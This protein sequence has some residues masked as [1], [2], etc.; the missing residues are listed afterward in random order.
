M[1]K[2]TLKEMVFSRRD[3]L[4]SKCVCE[5][6]CVEPPSD[7]KVWEWY[8]LAAVSA[9]ER[10]LS[11]VAHSLILPLQSQPRFTSRTLNSFIL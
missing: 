4:H 2:S 5:C 6:A 10:V 3:K 11:E 7:S 9:A 1:H 8:R